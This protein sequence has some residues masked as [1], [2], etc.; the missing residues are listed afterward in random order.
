[1]TATTPRI[2]TVRQNI[3]KANDA[4]NA[5][6]TVLRFVAFRS[7]IFRSRRLPAATPST[8]SSQEASA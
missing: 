1:M 6:A 8:Q 4:A 3:L 7:W 5:L 2:V